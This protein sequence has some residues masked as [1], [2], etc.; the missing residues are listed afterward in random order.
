MSTCICVEVSREKNDFEPIERIQEHEHSKNNNET[1]NMIEEIL[2]Q[3]T[4]N[5]TDGKEPLSSTFIEE[6]SRE[7]TENE[8]IQPRMLNLETELQ[9]NENTFPE[10]TEYFMQNQSEGN[11]SVDEV[12]NHLTPTEIRRKRSA[13]SQGNQIDLSNNGLSFNKVMI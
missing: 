11:V 8:G 4:T 12:N 2:L 10:D 5:D 6:L 3:H 13:D 1:Q 9:T 7:K